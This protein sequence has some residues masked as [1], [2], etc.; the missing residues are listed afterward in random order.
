MDNLGRTLLFYYITDDG[1]LLDWG[2]RWTNLVL[3]V[4]HLQEVGLKLVWINP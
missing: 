4:I 1:V 2:D 3:T